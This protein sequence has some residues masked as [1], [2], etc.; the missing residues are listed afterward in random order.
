AGRAACPVRSRPARRPHR[1]PGTRPETQT[2]L[3]QH[4]TSKRNRP[5]EQDDDHVATVLFC[6]RHFYFGKRVDAKEPSVL[7]EVDGVAAKLDLCALCLD[8]IT[9]WRDVV[10]LASTPEGI[11]EPDAFSRPQGPLK[12]LNSQSSA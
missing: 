1:P 12:F 2:N 3:T 8:A 11:Q 6:D 9:S 10:R 4:K 5:D 7:V